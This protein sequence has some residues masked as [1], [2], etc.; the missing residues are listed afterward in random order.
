MKHTLTWFALAF[1][2][3]LPASAMAQSSD[4]IAQR[5]SFVIGGERLTGI[6]F[7]SLKYSQPAG[8]N[9]SVDFTASGTQVNLL[10]GSNS[11]SDALINAASIPRIGADYFVTEIVSVGG[12]L[13]YTT[14]SGSVK[15]NNTG[16]SQ[17]SATVTGVA[18]APRVGFGFNISPSFLFWPRV[19]FQYTNSKIEPP[20]NN[21]TVTSNTL[22]GLFV[23]GMFVYSPVPHFGFG[24]G[25]ILELGLGGSIDRKTGGTTVSNDMKA[26][27]FGAIAGL[28]GYL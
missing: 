26:N 18:L 7:Y 28:V 6:Y 24:F 4:G 19:G 14:S 1:A 27:N 8:N 17:D 23:E 16:N 3:L 5:G 9:Q 10:W 13:G 12:S 22:Y 11:A 20:G 25:P 15:N 21:A 2:S